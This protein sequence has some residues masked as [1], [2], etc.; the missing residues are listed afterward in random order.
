MGM[1]R[2][3]LNVSRNLPDALLTADLANS[4]SYVSRALYVSKQAELSLPMLGDGDTAID[5]HTLQPSKSKK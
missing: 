3:I 4:G 2:V 5:N 1:F